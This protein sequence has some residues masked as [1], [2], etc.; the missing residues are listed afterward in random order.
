MLSAWDASM[1][2]I[3]AWEYGLRRVAPYAVVGRSGMSS[4]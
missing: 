2:K 1:L 3:L 4:I